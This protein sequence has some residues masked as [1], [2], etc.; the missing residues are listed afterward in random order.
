MLVSGT[1]SIVGHTSC[2]IGDLQAQLAEVWRNLE[3][4]RETAGATQTIA[5]RIYIRN[6]ADYPAIRAF[7][8]AQ[9][10]PDL[11]TIYQHADICRAE[12]LVEIEAVYAMP[13]APQ[14]T[15]DGE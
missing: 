2:H 5:V 11:A 14:D 4:L 8:D 10:A 1:A 7:L 3:S 9:L 15:T 13:Q 6:A 12:L